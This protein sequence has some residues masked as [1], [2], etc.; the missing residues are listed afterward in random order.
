MA[1]LASWWSTLAR[2]VSSV[3]TGP[4]YSLPAIA[5]LMIRAGLPPAAFFIF[6]F[7]LILA[8]V[9]LVLDDIFEDGLMRGLIVEIDL[10][11]LESLSAGLL[12]GSLILFINSF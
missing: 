11:G 7:V 4:D 10:S 2:P 9:M 6:G 3:D 12:V 8:Y 1:L 5:I